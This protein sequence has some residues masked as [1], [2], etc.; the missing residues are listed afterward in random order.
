MHLASIG[1][2]EFAELEIFCGGEHYVVLGF[3]RRR[4]LWR[5]EGGATT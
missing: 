3:M 4:V 2:G 5:K 1:V